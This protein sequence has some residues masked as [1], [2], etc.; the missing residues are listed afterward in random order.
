MKEKGLKTVNCN[1][2]ELGGLLAPYIHGNV[3]PRNTRILE[4]HLSTCEECQKKLGLAMIIATHGLR[5]WKRRD[6]GIAKLRH[7]SKAK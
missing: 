6:K 7:A 4:D 2:P 3:S 5:G 1:N